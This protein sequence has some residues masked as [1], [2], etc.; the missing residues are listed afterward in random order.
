MPILRHVKG[1]LYVNTW[2]LRRIP[3]T[4]LFDR[5][6]RGTSAGMTNLRGRTEIA[7][8]VPCTHGTKQVIVVKLNASPNG[9][10][11]SIVYANCGEFAIQ[12]RVIGII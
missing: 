5:N 10:T 8:C 1:R 9:L 11:L 4:H 12:L 3:P 2:F 7:V 6:E